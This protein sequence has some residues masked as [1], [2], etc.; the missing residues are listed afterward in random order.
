LELATIGTSLKED[1]LLHLLKTTPNIRRLDLE[2]A[3]LLTDA[4]LAAIT[5][6]A[7]E[8]SPA[9]PGHALEHLVI[10]HANGLTNEALLR[11]IRG[12]QR[13]TVLEADS[14]R[15]SSAVLR[16][17]VSL[18]KQRKALDT[19]VVAIDCRGISERLVKELTDSTRPRQG[20]R[21]YEAKKM[22]YMDGRDGALDGQDECDPSLVTLKTFYGWQVVDA[23]AV[24]KERK[25]KRQARRNGLDNDSRGSRWW[26]RSSSGSSSPAALF[27]NERDACVVM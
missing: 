23:V 1:G 26:S 8:S 12:C 18:S 14:T 19:K 16:E 6:S 13:L 2:D 11:L 20:W 25:R 22:K 3:S 24:E 15:L 5:P 17:F 27:D 7:S 10:S 21:A 4:F 9:E